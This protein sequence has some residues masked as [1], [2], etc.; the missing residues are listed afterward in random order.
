MDK[1][2]GGRSLQSSYRSTHVRIPEP[3]KDR[4]EAIKD[5]Y[6]SGGLQ[7]HEEL[8]AENCKLANEYKKVLTKSLTGNICSN[9]SAITEPNAT[10]ESVA[11]P[12][13]KPKGGRG[14][15]VDYISTHVRIPEPIK[16]KVEEIKDLYF[17]GSLQQYDELQVENC[18]LANEY[19]KM[20]TVTLTDNVCNDV[21]ATTQFV[22]FQDAL[23]IAK[24]L[25]HQEKSTRETIAEFLIAIYGINVK[26]DD[27]KL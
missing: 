19:R 12:V 25:L 27:L 15:K 20:L 13:N 1:P 3:I 9:I 7:Q 4:V 16:G 6:Y 26:V 21:S 23:A 14:L 5:L 24:K 22:F 11:S 8:Q 17:S 18:R 2:K 10:I